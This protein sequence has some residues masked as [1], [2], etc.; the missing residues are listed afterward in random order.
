MPIHIN[1]PITID[2]IVFDV[3][4]VIGVGGLSTV[5]LAQDQNSQEFV[6]IK[7]FMYQKFYD[8]ITRINDCEDYWENE[9]L[10]LIEQSKSGFPCVKLLHF[11][12]R[13]DL[14][15][16]EYYIVMN[17]VK[18]QT[19]LDFYRDFVQ[20]CRGMENLDLAGIMRNIFIPLAKHLEFCHEH[21]HIVHRDLS[22]SNII[23]IKDEKDDYWPVLIDWGL[24]KYV[25][26][27]WIHYVPHKYFA[28]DIPPDIP[29]KQKGSPPELRF[30]M[31][32]NATSD[33]YYLAHLM[34]FV[35]SG[36]IMREDA[37][38]KSD[39]DYILSPKKINWYI[40]EKYNEVVMQMTKYEPADRIQS[41]T[42]VVNILYELIK[43]NHIHFDF[44]F[45]MEQDTNEI[46][47]EKILPNEEE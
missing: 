24:S 23:V 44:D 39:L 2:G 29:I 1:K 36:G 45:F 11:E 6:A 14:Q 8:P 9:I 25:G 28:S 33:I 21:A 47:G 19:F 13:T 41:M 34:Y 43:I 3:K 42:E 31:L 35:F 4:K 20:Q 15:T 18:G 10:N 16:P 7:E 38:M 30:G 12:K 32:P 37:E 17:Y 26:A 40:P 27:D 22:V 5:F 46:T